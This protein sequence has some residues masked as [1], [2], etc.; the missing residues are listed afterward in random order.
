MQ[1]EKWWQ[2]SGY[3][4]F[5]P[6]VQIGVAGFHLATLLRSELGFPSSVRYRMS[7]PR[8]GARTRQN[9]SGGTPQSPVAML[10]APPPSSRSPS[11]SGGGSAPAAAPPPRTVIPKQDLLDALRGLSVDELACILPDSFQQSRVLSAKQK[12]DRSVELWKIAQNLFLDLLDDET[13]TRLLE[14]DAA[15]DIAG[16]TPD[17]WSSV[18]S[19]VLPGSQYK[20]DLREFPWDPMVDF[21]TKPVPPDVAR[22]FKF[23]P[24]IAAKEDVVKSILDKQLRPLCRLSLH[25][26]KM[27]VSRVPDNF[28]AMEA[29]FRQLLKLGQLVSQRV[30][31]MYSEIAQLRKSLCYQALGMTEAEAANTDSCLSQSDILRIRE[32]VKHRAEVQE[33]GLGLRRKAS[34]QKKHFKHRSKGDRGRAAGSTSSSEQLATLPASEAQGAST[35]AQSGQAA[36]PSKKQ[37]S[38]PTRQQGAGRGGRKGR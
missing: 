18:F 5:V 35:S 32:V 4:P 27:S 28:A 11:T 9:R 16:T 20:P 37:G 15:G 22:Q 29:N 8:A 36:Q 33:L 26:S 1:S 13:H 6:V 14:L 21:R 34:I 23:K 10:E 31:I 24:Q 12:E 3:V 30:W 17:F 19:S 25:L 38:T 7:T 2:K